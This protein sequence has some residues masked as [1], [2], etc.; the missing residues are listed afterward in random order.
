[1]DTQIQEQLK[2]KKIL[3]ATAPGDGHFN[4]L[5]G[6]AKHLQG[7]GCD[8]RWFTSEY[9]AG[10]LNKM[11]I[12]HYGYEKTMNLRG[13]NIDEYLNR[14]TIMDPLERI[15]FDIE[16]LCIARAPESYEDIEKINQSFPFDLLIADSGFTAAPLVKYGLNK[17]VITIG[18]VPLV[19][20]TPE[21]APVGMALPPATDEATIQA[22][23]GMHDQTVNV[24]FKK[25]VDM[26]GDLLTKFGIEHKRAFFCDQL[27]KLADLYLQIG[28]PSF[29]YQERT[30]TGKNVR[31]IGAL[32][33]YKATV[34][35]QHTPWFDERLN[36]YKKVILVTQ[37]TVE[38]DTTKL[39]EPTLEAFKDNSEV[40]VIATTA[41]SNNTDTLKEKY[42]DYKNIIIENFIPFD[43]VMPHVDAYVT[44]G[45]Y[46]GCLLGISYQLPMVVAGL[47]EGK[48]EICARVGYLKYGI[49]LNTETPTAAA[50]ATAVEELSS[51]GIYKENIVRL[52]HEMMEY[53]AFER[54]TGYVAELLSGV[55]A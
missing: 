53:N 11:G 38:K 13:D 15:N 8:V 9:F 21:L 36:E 24:L 4:P 49:N 16:H 10:K 29:D 51:N 19:E 52:H 40:L 14:K 55:K 5:T 18:V 42:R 43:D 50:I 17:P 41:G 7:L 2:G 20:D 30:Q 25:I 28:T 46:G 23:A 54:C 3:F 45:G 26:Y 1:M 34:T 37:G 6:L 39:T 48:N 35:E 22:Y 44:N 12:Q 27:V 32:L 31:F 47:Y 33:P